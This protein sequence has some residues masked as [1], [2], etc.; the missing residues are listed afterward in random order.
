MGIGYVVVGVVLFAAFITVYP[1]GKLAMGI[2]F[3]V[4]LILGTGMGRLMFVRRIQP[5]SEPRPGFKMT[6]NGEII[7]FGCV[8]PLFAAALIVGLSVGLHVLSNK[9]G[10]QIDIG[11]L[12]AGIGSAFIAFFGIS[13]IGSG[14]REPE[15]KGAHVGPGRG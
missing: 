4:S 13:F 8:A 9:A 10:L 6:R 3:A 5:L 14:R 7:V 11:A 2:A 12:S 15:L 1:D